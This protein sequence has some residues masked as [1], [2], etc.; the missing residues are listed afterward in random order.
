ML[1]RSAIAAALVGLAVWQAG[2]VATAQS[3]RRPN[4]DGPATIDDLL[5]RNRG[6][7]AGQTVSDAGVRLGEGA[8]ISGWEFPPSPDRWV[9]S[10]PLTVESLAGKGVVMLFFEEECAA[11]AARWSDLLKLSA[12]YTDRPVLFLAV[13]SGPQASR[14]GAYARKHRITWPVIADV[15][16]SFETQ[17]SVAQVS[18]SNVVHA[19]YVT[20]DGVAHPGKWSDL[21]GT[22]QA[23]LEGAAWK[24]DPPAPRELADAWRAI[25]LGAYADAAKAVTRYAGGEKNGPLKSFAD[26]LLAAVN[27]AIDADYSQAG[28]AYK[29][30]EHWRAYKLLT[31]LAERYDGYEIP[32]TVEPAIKELKRRDSVAGEIKAK[33]ALDKAIRTASRGSD[34]AVR[35]GVGMLERLIASSPQ[36]EA[37]EEAKKIL[38]SRQ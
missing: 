23:A 11:C 30:G 5:E 6:P 9:N 34:A 2:G 31:A 35:R 12:Q 38:A 8:G 14:I 26:K 20:A 3:S 28:D 1:Q 13:N 24:V 27:E 10:P 37:A 4:P 7:R 16:R 25:E 29:E 15:D 18:M 17:M 21:A 19:L 33:A 32:P 36:T 22:A